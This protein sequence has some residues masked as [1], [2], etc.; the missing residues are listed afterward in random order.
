MLL[1]GS[2]DDN[3]FGAGCEGLLKLFKVDCPVCGRGILGGASLGR[4]EG[5]VDD[6]T[7]GHL[8]VADVS[9]GVLGR[10]SKC[11]Q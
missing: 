5:H 1:T 8:N 4:V 6:F 3:H 11:V 10:V 7:T 2:V 9:M